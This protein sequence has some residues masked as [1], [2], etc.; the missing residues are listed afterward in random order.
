LGFLQPLD[1]GN[2]K[3]ERLAGAGLRRGQYIP[4]LERRRNRADLYRS[5]RNKV[6]FGEALFERCRDG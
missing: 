4:A 1:D 2:E 5:E 6:C 3:A